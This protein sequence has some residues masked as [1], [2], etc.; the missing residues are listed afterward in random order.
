MSELNCINSLLDSTSSF[1]RL[2]LHAPALTQ[3]HK[4]FLSLLVSLF[5]AFP[6]AIRHCFPKIS[7]RMRKILLYSFIFFQLRMLPWSHTCPLLN[8]TRQ[9]V[10]LTKC[11]ARGKPLQGFYC[12]SPTQG[13]YVVIVGFQMKKKTI[14]NKLSLEWLVK[15]VVMQR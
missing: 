14:W 2:I 12:F 5:C 13:L 10:R 8:Q 9:S 6:G 1:R 15:R 11:G 4:K 3:L 7:S